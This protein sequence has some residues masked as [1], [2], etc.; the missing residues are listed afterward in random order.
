MN[1]S[2]FFTVG[3]IISL[4][5]FVVPHIIDLG[6]DSLLASSA[7]GMIGV[8]SAVGSFIFGIISDWIGRKYTIIVCA[9]GIAFSIF[10][11]TI[12]P[13]N[14]TMLYVWATLYGLTYGGLP[15]QYA[16]M[17][18]DYFGTKHGPS[19]F[20]IIF[21]MGSLGGGLLPLI[22]GYLADLT[23]NYYATLVFLGFGMCVAVATILPVKP[24]RRR[25]STIRS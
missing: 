9:T 8:M 24:P 14:I 2:Y 5:T 12:I 4:L 25:V 17:V 7:F 18:A 15:E 19:L 11:S 20:G 16:T 10:I 21:F 1:V 6:I 23:G 13:S 22:G 3:V